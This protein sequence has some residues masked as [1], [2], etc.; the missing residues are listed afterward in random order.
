[1]NLQP[2]HLKACTAQ[3]FCISLLV[4]LILV[5]GAVGMAYLHAKPPEP[6]IIDLSIDSPSSTEACP[7]APPLSARTTTRKSAVA[8]T[9]VVMQTGAEPTPPVPTPEIKAATETNSTATPVPEAVAQT[10]S[11]VG[12]AHAVEKQSTAAGAVSGGDKGKATAVESLSGKTAGTGQG[13]ADYLREHFA[14]IRDIIKKNTLYPDH[15]RRMGWSGKVLLSFIV[16]EDG[17]VHDVKIIQGTGFPMLDNGAV[18]A[19]KR[20]AP[21]PRPPVRAEIVLPVSYRLF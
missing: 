7:S 8:T 14:Y 13:K 11:F 21:F 12:T 10:A 4:H 3:W 2:G 1:M 17:T 6:V 20:S 16:A 18:D 15:A 19:V 9:P 5:G